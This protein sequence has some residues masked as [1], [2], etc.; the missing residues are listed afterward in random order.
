MFIDDVDEWT[1]AGVL[2]ARSI[3]VSVSW[4]IDVILIVYV[5]VFVRVGAL[6]LAVDM[7]MR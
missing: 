7:L 1:C 3:G 2:M 6:T 5:A 4:F